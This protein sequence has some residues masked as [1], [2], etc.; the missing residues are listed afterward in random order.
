MGFKN[1]YRTNH[2]PQFGPGGD[3]LN[4]NQ[5]NENEIALLENY[6]PSLIYGRSKPEAPDN[7]V[8]ATVAFDKKVLR[9]YGYFKQTVYESPNE[10]FR[11]RPVTIVYFLEDDSMQ[12]YENPVENSGIPQVIFRSSL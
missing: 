12:I 11:V 7:F 1:G 9:F 4:Y 5:L 8:P 2:M 6:K 10:F 3:R